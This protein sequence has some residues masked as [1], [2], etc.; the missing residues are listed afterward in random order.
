[1]NFK[2][3]ISKPDKIYINKGWKGWADFL[4]KEENPSKKSTNK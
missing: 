1:M 3:L 4:G 2:L